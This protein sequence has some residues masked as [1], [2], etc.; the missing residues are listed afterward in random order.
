MEKVPALSPVDLAVTTGD[1]HALAAVMH[2]G[3]DA[4]V[5]SGALLLHG[6]SQQARFWDPVVR[7]LRSRPV[8]ALDQRGHGRS[9][10]PRGVDYSVEACAHDA[11][12]AIV[13]SGLEHP[14]IVGHSW[15]ASVALSAAVHRPDLVRAIVLIDGGA[16]S[17]PQHADREAARERLRPPALGMPS[18]E[19][20]SMI[21]ASSPWFTS[22]THAA[23]EPT[24]V[25]GA[26]GGIRTRIGVDRHMAVLDGILDFD[27]AEAWGQLAVPA[28]I[29]SCE[30]AGL[31]RDLSIVGDR[32]DRRILRWE[33]AVHDVPLQWPSLVAGLIDEVLER[34]A[35]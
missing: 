14:V 7:R 1:G 15:G 10:L 19:L 12:A 22:E 21:A 33:G 27:V 26:D 24:F 4:A 3:S 34:A 28:W 16:W 6:L 17:I 20:W 23:L 35:A 32:D 31:P 25:V 30:E 13:A 18:E 5:G 8:V 11:I 29:V 2:V 9:D